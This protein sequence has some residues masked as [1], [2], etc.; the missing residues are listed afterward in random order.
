MS[1]PSAT[2]QPGAEKNPML[3]LGLPARD[4]T[5]DNWI[6]LPL[7]EAPNFTRAKP[8]LLKPGDTLYR[9]YGGGASMSGGYWS[10]H[11]PAADCTE[12]QWRKENAIELSWNA[13]TDVAK[14]TVE[15]GQPLQVWTGGVES[16]PAQDLNGNPL[17]DYWLVGEGTQFWVKSFPAPIFPKPTRVGPT[18]WIASRQ[19]VLKAVALLAQPDELDPADGHASQARLVAQL[20]L[21]LESIADALSQKSGV[22]DAALAT[23]VANLKRAANSLVEN[24]G[25]APDTLKTMARAQVGL[26][27]HV[28][29]DAAWQ[30]APAL[31]R[32]L[33]AVVSGAARLARIDG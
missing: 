26:G 11:P 12:A 17:P 7:R 10:P 6:T 31:N 29:I 15:D 5:A 30:D 2:P 22:A 32:T 13:G 28:Q 21:S 14:F 19:T 8:H 33:D 23:T 18:P 4:V 1:D 16:Q 25:G 24:L 27:R 3:A 20:A 9:V